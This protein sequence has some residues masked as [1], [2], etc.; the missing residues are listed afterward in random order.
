MPGLP[1]PPAGEIACSITTCNNNTWL[2]Y[3]ILP[4]S[5]RRTYAIFLYFVALCR[6]PLPRYTPPAG[7]LASF[8]RFLFLSFFCLLGFVYTQTLLVLGFLVGMRC[9]SRF[10]L[11]VSLECSMHVCTSMGLITYADF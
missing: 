6:L 7:E 3:S 2:P 1:H 5:K 4:I 10:Q 8:L 9:C 11:R